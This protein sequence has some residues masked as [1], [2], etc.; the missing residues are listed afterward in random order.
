VIRLLLLLQL[1]VPLVPRPE[2]HTITSF[3]A[4]TSFWRAAGAWV[5]ATAPEENAI[6][7]TGL[8]REHMIVWLNFSQA[9]VLGSAPD[10]VAFA[11]P[12]NPAQIGTGHAHLDVAAKMPCEHSAFTRPDGDAGGDVITLAGSLDLFSLVFCDNGRA[13]LLMQDGRRQS[14][15]WR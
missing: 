15:S 4:D 2:T 7:F 8:V 10:S 5:T 14:F 13:E 12:S 3:A 11:C 9:Q 6:C 1:Q